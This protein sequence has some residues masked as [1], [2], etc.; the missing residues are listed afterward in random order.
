MDKP[1]FLVFLIGEEK[2]KSKII[3]NKNKMSPS[4]WIKSRY[5]VVPAVIIPQFRDCK[6]FSQSGDFPRGLAYIHCKFIW[7]G[8][9]T[10]WGRHEGDLL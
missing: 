4:V 7:T 10:P 9:K 2:S 6:M 8:L 1:T 3:N 5:R